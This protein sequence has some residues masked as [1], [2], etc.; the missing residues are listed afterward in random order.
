VS[1]GGGPDGEA[2]AAGGGEVEVAPAATVVVLR[3]GAEGI[4]A[5]LL[6]RNPRLAFSAGAWVF[7][8][9]RVDPADVTAAG[10]TDPFVR[11][12]GRHAAA[13]ELTE[14]AGLVVPA[15]DL[16]PW[17]H[18]TTPPGPPR[19]FATWFFVAAASEVE[20]VVVD[21]GEIHASDWVTPATAESRFRAR[22]MELAPPTWLT[23]RQVGEH[24]DVA[25]VLEAARSTADRVYEPRI[26]ETADGR[27][28]SLYEGDAGWPTSDP[29]VPGPRHRILWLPDDYRFERSV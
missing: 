24:P 9:G 21:G 7:P 13:R 6:R 26:A 10:A 22:E 27:L 29:E 17:S 14:E 19:R 8:G 18:W 4:E 2:V 3:D 25:A 15:E 11:E 5:L 1:R 12:A 20:D 28:V 23:L 16:V